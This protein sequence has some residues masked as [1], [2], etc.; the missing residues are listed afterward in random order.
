MEHRLALTHILSIVAYKNDHNYDQVICNRQHLTFIT[1]YQVL[2]R[3]Q[4]M[5]NLL[6]PVCYFHIIFNFKLV[7]WRMSDDIHEAY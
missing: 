1:F 7:D 2:L 5:I 4:L 3:V 6:S